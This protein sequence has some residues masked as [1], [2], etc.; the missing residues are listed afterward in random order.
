MHGHALLVHIRLFLVGSE[1]K[2]AVAAYL[3]KERGARDST[4]YLVGVAE[5]LTVAFHIFIIVR[6]YSGSTFARG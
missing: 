5:R 2:C 6:T 1:V 4:I 3:P